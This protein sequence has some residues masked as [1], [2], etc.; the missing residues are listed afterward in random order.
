MNL[1]LLILRLVAGGLLAGHGAQKLFGSFGGGGLEGTGGWL[2][3]MGLRPGKS[4]AA[5]AG[6]GELGSGALTALGLFTPVGP[7]GVFGPMLM[8]TLKAHWGKPIWVTA[9]GAELPVMYMAGASALM[10]AGPGSFSLDSLFGI[11]VPKP[12]V[13][14][15]LLFSVGGVVVGMVNPDLEAEEA[16]GSQQPDSASEAKVD[17]ESLAV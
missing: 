16:G 6:A 10:F 14:L 15:A 12:L 4:W 13:A 9:G 7:I 8:A 3:S 5:L 17:A 11:R 1:G 2:E